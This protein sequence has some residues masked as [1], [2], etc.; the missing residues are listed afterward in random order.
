MS[1]PNN[2]PNSEHYTNW[3]NQ[4]VKS[5]NSGMGNVYQQ[6]QQFPQKPH[7]SPPPSFM[8]MANPYQQMMGGYNPY[9]QWQQCQL[10][11]GRRGRR[12]RGRHHHHDETSSDSESEDDSPD[13][14]VTVCTHAPIGPLP[15]NARQCD[16]EYGNH[17][18][19][20]NRLCVRKARLN[21]T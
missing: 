6:Q 3:Y 11:G 4:L 8:G 19:E 1:N 12:G 7:R 13:G 21:C 5:W 16:P 10:G 18:F 17:R 9:Q 15:E 2:I 20:G 14:H